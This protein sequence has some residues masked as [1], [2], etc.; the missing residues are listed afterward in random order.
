MRSPGTL[1]RV[2]V[3]IASLTMGGKVFNLLWGGSGRTNN[4][5]LGRSSAQGAKRVDAGSNKYSLLD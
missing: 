3:L 5:C 2:V 1:L 4:Q